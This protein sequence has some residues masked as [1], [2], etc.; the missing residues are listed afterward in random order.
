MAPTT[1][2]SRYGG[3]LPKNP[4]I[5]KAFFDERIALARHRKQRNAAHEPA[6]AA[7][8]AAIDNDP[9]M[10]FLFNNIFLQVSPIE[11]K[12]VSNVFTGRSLFN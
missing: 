5:H 7:F 9:T 11:P 8:G 10:K 3:W 6:V 2:L 12:C 4:K 1:A